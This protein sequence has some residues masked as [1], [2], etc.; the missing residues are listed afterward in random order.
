MA[1]P[2]EEFSIRTGRGALA[3]TPEPEPGSP[4]GPE[5]PDPSEPGEEPPPF[6]AEPDELEDSLQA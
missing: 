5:P 4:E 2:A 6:P 3:E 1:T